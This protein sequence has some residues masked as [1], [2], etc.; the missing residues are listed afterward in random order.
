MRFNHRSLIVFT[1]VL[2]FT[3]AASTCFAAYEVG[4]THGTN[5]HRAEFDFDPVNTFAIACAQN[6]WEPFQILIRS[7]QAVSNV[8][9]AI[10]D[11]TGPGNPIT[12]I[13]PYRIRYQHVYADEISHKP[14]DV[15]R[16]GDWPD[17]LVPFVDHFTG[18]DRDGAPFDLVP[19]STQGIFVDVF[20][21]A[22]QTAGEYTATVTVTAN[23]QADWTGTVT[24]TVWDFELPNGLSLINNYQYSRSG[25][26]DYHTANGNTTDCEE[27]H[28]KYF[29]EF[30]RHRMSTYSWITGNPPYNYDAGAQTLTYDWTAWDAYHGPYLDGT[31]Y[32]PGYEFQS[33]KL[34]RSFSSPPTGI[35]QDEWNIM[36]WAKWAEHFKQK[37]W[38]EK[39][40]CYMPDEPS[41]DEY[42]ALLQ[43]AANIHL[44]DPDL[45]PF[46]TEQYTELLGDDIDIWCPDEPL[47][48]DSMPWPPYPEKYQELRDQ[49][50]KTWWYNCVSATLGFDYA[51][52]MVDQESTYMRSWLWLTRRYEFTGI[53]FWRI[54]YLWSRQDVW[55]DIYADTFLCQGDGTL[56][57]PGIPS[58]IG[59][60]T[61]IPIPS[62]RIKILREAMEDYEY[63]HILD[64]QGMDDWVDDITRTVAPK[65]Y[66]WEHDWGKMLDWRRMVA[67]KILGTLDETPPAAPT[68]LAAAPLEES[69]KLTWT[70]PSDTDLAGVEIFYAVY[71]GDEFFGGS[72]DAT[73]TSATVYG[74]TP[75]VNYTF[76]VKAFDQNQNRSEK[77]DTAVVTPTG[78]TGDD[79]EHVINAVS[80]G[81]GD[82]DESNDAS[83][84]DDS[85]G[86]GGWL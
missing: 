56:F 16:A 26:C 68:A 72:V 59:G 22:G 44:A 39:L 41:P 82:D 49:G 5:K 33:V 84:D 73:A 64:Q 67:E 25:I 81:R 31:F 76:W 61:D 40:W 42:P 62:L 74:L 63:F 58:K 27:L 21:P 36:H 80:V 15:S 34:P 60:T 70:L 55:E 4:L 77:S 83:D 71:E 79:K 86:C 11:F 10:T 57:Y 3:F 14:P 6:E 85:F 17:G 53:L 52:H 66:Q 78:D 47:F 50:K 9:V 12:E 65:T 35:T 69:A 2:I 32:K 38:I 23:G 24:L 30:A 43:L 46:V 1:L 54:N 19:N 45:Q 28:Q 13:E 37:G 51:T 18:E 8:D 48:S 75:G 7:D 29:E 20:V